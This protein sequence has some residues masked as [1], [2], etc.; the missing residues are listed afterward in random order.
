MKRILVVDDERE[1]LELTKRKLDRLGYEV[2]TAINGQEALGIVRKDPPPDLI[3]LDVQMPVMNGYS[4]MLELKRMKDRKSVPVI[5]TTA[6][7]EM[8]PIFTLKGVR[9]YLVKPIKMEELV[10]K[11]QQCLGKSSPSPEIQENRSPEIS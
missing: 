5:V 8:Q 11:I 1:V 2:F 9:G 4:F 6:Y 7:S 10:E 3:L